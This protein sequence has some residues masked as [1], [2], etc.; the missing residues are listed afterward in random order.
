MLLNWCISTVPP[1]QRLET[2]HVQNRTPQLYLL[3][4]VY[5]SSVLDAGF[6]TQDVKAGCNLLSEFIVTFSV[7]SKQVFV[8]SQKRGS[9]P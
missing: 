1:F 9:E 8:V 7:K 5:K 2:C 6:A 4:P 3:D